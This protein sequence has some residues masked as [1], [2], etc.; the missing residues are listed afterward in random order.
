VV[1]ILDIDVKVLVPQDINGTDYQIQNVLY[2]VTLLH[3]KVLYNKI[4]S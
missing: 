3:I 2:G 1:V 4:I